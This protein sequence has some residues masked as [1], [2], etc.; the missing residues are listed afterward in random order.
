MMKVKCR[1]CGEILA[2]GDDTPEARASKTDPFYLIKTH[3]K[4]H[5]FQVLKMMSDGSIGRFLD[6]LVFEGLS[7]GD[8]AVWRAHQQNLFNFIRTP[9]AIK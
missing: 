1:L 5:M 7:E 6:S 4:R 2:M 8:S 9:E 3:N